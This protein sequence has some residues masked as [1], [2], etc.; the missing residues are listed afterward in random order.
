MKTLEAI[1][2]EAARMQLIDII[3]VTEPEKYRK[4]MSGYGDGYKNFDI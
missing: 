2:E 3:E 4:K 1:P